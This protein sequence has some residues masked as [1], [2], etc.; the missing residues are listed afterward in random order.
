M[1][2]SYKIK[3][4]DS[5]RLLSTSLSSLADTISIRLHGYKCTDCGSFLDYMIPRD[6]RLIFR[7]FECRKNCEKD[8]SKEL[9]KRFANTY[10]FCNRDI[11]KFI[12]LLRKG[13]YPY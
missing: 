9:I 2:I 13:V 7:C 6:D 8:Y 12:L 1:K 5:F 3:F 4:T 10:E 11:N